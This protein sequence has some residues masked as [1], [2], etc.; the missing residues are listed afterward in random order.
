LEFICNLSFVIWDLGFKQLL[1]GIETALM[2]NSSFVN[3]T[4]DTTLAVLVM[5]GPDAAIAKALG[6]EL[7]Q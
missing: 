4:K 3:Y 2:V 6:E 5:L 7:S 1:S